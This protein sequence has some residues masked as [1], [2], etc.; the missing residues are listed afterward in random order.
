MM[1]KRGKEKWI[2][3]A[4]TASSITLWFISLFQSR[5]V[6]GHFGL[7]HS[8]TPTYYLSFILLFIAFCVLYPWNKYQMLLFSQSILLIAFLW[9][10][11][12][13]IGGSQPVLAHVYSFWGNIDLLVSH[14]HLSEDIC[15]YHAWP[16]S[17][18]LYSALIVLTG[19]ENADIIIAVMPFLWQL[20]SLPFL[21]LLMKKISEGKE[22]GYYWVGVWLF[23]LG[24]WVGQSYL[25]PQSFAYLLYLLILYVLLIQMNKTRGRGCF[26]IYLLFTILSISI[27]ITHVV[28]SLLL[29]GIIFMLSFK[30][31][32]GAVPLVLLM[33]VLITWNFYGTL[34]AFPRWG[35]QFFSN[36]FNIEFILFQS[37]FE[38]F[39]GN[40]SRLVVIRVRFVTTLIVAFI[41]LIGY[42]FSFIKE[43][44][45]H[46]TTL[47]V[48]IG[49]TLV[50][51]IFGPGI[52]FEIP[53]RVYY[54]SL[55]LLAYFGSNLLKWKVIN[56]ILVILLLV[57]FPLHLISHYGNQIVDHQSKADITAVKFFHNTVEE[58]IIAGA[59]PSWIGEFSSAR[60]FGLYKNVGKYVL[61]KYEDFI[62]EKGIVYR[63]IRPPPPSYGSTLYIPFGIRDRNL[64]DFI[65]NN[66]QAYY[67]INHILNNSTS[68]DLVYNNRDISLYIS[69]ISH[70]AMS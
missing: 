41:G 44:R 36:I 35:P 3:L 25:S 12:L 37:F 40:S 57:L 61:L 24:N 14:A 22:V 69:E 67:K 11:P 33:I 17:W 43:K 28:T 4:L 50:T 1:S 47:K 20:L 42:F 64:Y 52:G 68:I 16:G 38:R 23:F 18:I 59:T 32:I 54:F 55:P 66:T 2:S 60:P 26:N 34:M 70:K 29:L 6:I 45:L 49:L 5:L 31:G 30:K 13:F 15:W 46:V 27:V 8:F 63:Y 10:S 9:L 19:I 58:G 56:T 51:L 65:Y 62:W 53:Y 48:F 7:I 39:Q 21:C